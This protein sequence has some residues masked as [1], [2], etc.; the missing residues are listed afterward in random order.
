MLN[1]RKHDIK[2]IE[3]G[4]KSSN[5]TE[6][7]LAKTAG[8]K[9]RREQRDTWTRQARERLVEE[10]RKGN[11]DNATDIRDTMVKHRGGRIGKENR[12]ELLT[13]GIHWEP[14]QYERIFGHE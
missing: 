10:T 2:T 3:K 11:I 8:E 12:G 14:N 1:T 6:V 13:L 5:P 7:Q 9:I 4:L